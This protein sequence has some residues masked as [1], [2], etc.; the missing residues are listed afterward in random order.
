MQDYFRLSVYCEIQ[1]TF[2]DSVGLNEVL[3][4]NNLLDDKAL[5]RKF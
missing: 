1:N 2:I 5:V 3:V 4:G